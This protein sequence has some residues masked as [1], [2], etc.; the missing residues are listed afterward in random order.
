MNYQ[1]FSPTLKRHTITKDVRF[2]FHL[3]AGDHG[4]SDTL[5]I[6]NAYPNALIYAIEGDLLKYNKVSKFCERTDNITVLHKFLTEIDYKWM[7]T[8]D[9]LMKELNIKEIDLMYISYNPYNKAM[10]N[11]AVETL[12]KTK[13]IILIE[14]SNYDLDVVQQT[15]FLK[16]NNFYQIERLHKCIT[17][18]NELM[19]VVMFQNLDYKEPQICPYIMKDMEGL[20]KFTNSMS[21]Y[22]YVKNK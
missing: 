15:D 6:H 13:Q 4:G 12:K 20:V 9:S 22:D 18:D 5:M 17:V 10:L 19:D 21:I 2:I 1:F 7:E 14:R 3:N 8:F 11:G 16:S